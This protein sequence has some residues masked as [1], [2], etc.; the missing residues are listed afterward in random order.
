MKLVAVMLSSFRCFIAP[1]RIELANLTT[2]VGR[3]D[4]GKS[5]ILEALETFFNSDIVAIVAQDANV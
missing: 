4:I 1:I 2:F 5:R 3:N